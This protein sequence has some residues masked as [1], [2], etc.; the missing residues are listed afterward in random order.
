MPSEET[1]GA[2]LTSVDAV[3]GAVMILMALDH[4]RDFFHRGAIQF[5]PTDLAKTTPVLFLTR[6]VTHFCLPAFMF[7]TGIGAFLWLRRRNR[8]KKELASFLA[9]RGVLFVLL[10]LT[11]LQFAY[12]FNIPTHYLVLLLV[13]WIFGICL[14]PM[15]LLVELPTRWLAVV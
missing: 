12:D 13:L 7:T 9:K 14:I 6:W 10:E 5:S 4:V 1:S 15:A 2:R 8:T 11:V 3:R